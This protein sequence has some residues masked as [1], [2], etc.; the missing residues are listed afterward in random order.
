MSRIPVAAPGA[1]LSFVFFFFALTLTAFTD[2]A[3]TSP[4]MEPAGATAAATDTV[5][6]LGALGGTTGE[7]SDME[8]GRIVG[9][10]EAGEGQFHA[11]LW[12]N[13]VMRDL[14]A[15]PAILPTSRA[16]AINTAVQVVGYGFAEL[17]NGNSAEH[18]FLWQNGTML[19]LGTLG[20][21]DSR[22]STST[23]RGSSSA[24]RRMPRATCGRCAGSTASSRGSAR[25]AAR[26]A[27]GSASTTRV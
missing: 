23:R 2:D 19:D 8:G 18:G 14:G 21:P 1:A 4:S 15:L 9:H 22:R 17:P 10:A 7:A 13:G 5:I 26:P 24:S 27:A 11:F 12:E 20:G 6:P 3:P 25:L 16:T